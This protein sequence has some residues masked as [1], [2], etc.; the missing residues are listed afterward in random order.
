MEF[1]TS[2]R[3]NDATTF[4][5]ATDLGGGGNWWNSCSEN[6]I[7]G[8]YG[9]NGGVKSMWWYG[10]DNNDMSLKSMTLMYRQAH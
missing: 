7:N 1:S 8:R 6:N 3:D 2:D 9:D 5:C 4:N 10:F